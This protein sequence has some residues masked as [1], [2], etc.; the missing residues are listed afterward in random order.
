MV[1]DLGTF[2]NGGTSYAAAL[3]S[4]GC[5]VGTAYLD[6]SGAD[7]F[8]AAVWLPGTLGA[9][10]LNNLIPQTAG[11]LLRQATGINDAGQIVGWGYVNNQTRAFRLSPA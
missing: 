8:R 3:N 1:E 7:N 9:Q 10:N 11:W 5:V 4:N 2:P 6:A